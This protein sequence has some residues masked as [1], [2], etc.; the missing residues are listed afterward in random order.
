MARIAAIVLMAFAAGVDG[1]AMHHCQNDAEDESAMLAIKKYNSTVGEHS[2]NSKLVDEDGNPTWCAQFISGVCPEISGPCT[3]SIATCNAILSNGAAACK[4]ALPNGQKAKA[5]V[6]VLP[7]FQSA[8]LK[9]LKM[10]ATFTAYSCKT[11]M[12]S[13]C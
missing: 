1:A 6:T 12:I 4:L 13:N 9:V 8:C 3:E 11:V 10:Q 5:C 7:K 2:E